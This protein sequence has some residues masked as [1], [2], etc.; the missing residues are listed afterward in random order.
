VEFV[1]RGASI[2]GVDAGDWGRK[3]GTV[4]LSFILGFDFFSTKYSKTPY[5]PGW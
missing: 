4:I 3:M 2:W 5:F 1:A